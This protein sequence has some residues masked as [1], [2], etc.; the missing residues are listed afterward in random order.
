MLSPC[1]SPTYA[2]RHES[3]P[4]KRINRISKAFLHTPD[5]LGFDTADLFLSVFIVVSWLMTTPE[6]TTQ[7][8]HLAILSIAFYAHLLRATMHPE[9]PKIGS[10]QGLIITWR[11]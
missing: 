6:P 7:T 9:A 3:P 1:G 11:L 2:P 4:A 5:V 8:L 10:H